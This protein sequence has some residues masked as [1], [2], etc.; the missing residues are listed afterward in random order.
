M[1]PCAEINSGQVMKACLPPVG[2][3]LAGRS[4]LTQIFLFHHKYRKI[5]LLF[6]GKV[7]GTRVTREYRSNPNFKQLNDPMTGNYKLITDH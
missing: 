3:R 2:L 7:R 1:E 4:L 5:S 6:Q